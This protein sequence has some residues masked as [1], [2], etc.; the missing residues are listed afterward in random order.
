MKKTVVA[1]SIV[2]VSVASW[3]QDAEPVEVEKPKPTCG[4]RAVSC[5]TYDDGSA[6]FAGYPGD[7]ILDTRSWTRSNHWDVACRRDSMTD[8][9][10]CHL[11]R[12]DFWLFV[13]PDEK[14]TI[15][16]GANNFPGRPIAIRVGEGQPF[17]VTNK[18]AAFDAA[19]SQKI[20]AQL[21][22]HETFRTRY[23]QWPH[24]S[25]I[26]AEYQ[27]YGFTEAYE[28]LRRTTQQ[29]NRKK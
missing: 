4:K 22:K 29:L 21:E 3:A 13:G 14:P 7:D 10:T 18:A 17:S 19:T 5:I 1:I 11:K 16:I 25:W 23:A 26:D 8:R 28:Y 27:T 6:N 2:V 20:I 9:T 12:G 15:T 24:E